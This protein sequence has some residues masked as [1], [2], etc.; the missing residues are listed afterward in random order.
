[1]LVG[2]D[3]EQNGASECGTVGR[4]RSGY[5]LELRTAAAFRASSASVLRRK[6]GG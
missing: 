1:M 5:Q 3:E 6:F 4:V 2:M